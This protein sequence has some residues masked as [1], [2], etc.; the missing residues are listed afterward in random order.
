MSLVCRHREIPDI[1]NYDVYVNQ[2]DGYKG[3][4]KALGLTRDEVIDIAKS[5]GL[6]GRGGA[7]F[8][9]GL[10]WS[11]MT[12]KVQGPVYFEVNCAVSSPQIYAAASGWR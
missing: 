6:R 9:T 1:H 12:K 4:Q 8:P 10:K 5:S 2:A 11:F 7:G 3:L